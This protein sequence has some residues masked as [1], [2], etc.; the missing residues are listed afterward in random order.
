LRCQEQFLGSEDPR[1]DSTLI[2]PFCYARAEAIST[3]STPTSGLGIFRRTF[4]A[5]KLIDDPSAR[6]RTRERTGRPNE[7]LQIEISERL[8]FSQSGFSPQL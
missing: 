8:N 4:H 5:T 6:G 7:R 1:N 3:N 2:I